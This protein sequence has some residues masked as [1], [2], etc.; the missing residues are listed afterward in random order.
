[1]ITRRQL[2]ETS[3]A[4]G[5]VLATVVPSRLAAQ[6]S[7]PLP[8][9]KSFKPGEIWNDTSGKLIQAH[10][11]AII[12]VDGIFYWYGENKE[13]TTG[14]TKT[15]SWGIRIYRSVDLYNWD[16]AG[17]LI[18]PDTSGIKSALSPMVFPERPHI[19]YNSRTKKFV[20]WIKIRGFGPEYRII[21]T[22]DKITGPYVMVKDS[23][24]PV[25]MV[26]G[27]FDM[28]VS[29]DDGKAYIYFEHVHKE[30]VCAD[31][32]DDYLDTTGNYSTHFPRQVPL[33]REGLA[34]FSRKG[35]HY[36]ASSGMTGYYPNPSEIAV[37]DMYHGPFTLLGDLHPS[38]RSRSSFNSQI[39]QIFRHPDKGDLYI[40]LADRWLP[41]LAGPD[42]E[43]GEDYERI[44][45]GLAKVTAIPRQT[46]SREEIKVLSRLSA[47]SGINTSISRY[48]WLPVTF[49]NDRPRIEWRDEW[50]IEEYS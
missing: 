1:M 44:L 17:L 4:A 8:R 14:K 15:E 45:S 3:F 39:S 49:K 29:P 20:C 22:A 21:L 41:D 43:S 34:Y 5:L 28:A 9:R 30:V 33:V 38:D 46:M 19:L 24:R 40:A 35:K 16:D 12:H 50:S 36:L 7:T 48:I 2:I 11:G 47:L 42:F 23:V 32:T 10:A 13:F 37:A 25:G 18:A 31:L 26:A 27:D 6:A